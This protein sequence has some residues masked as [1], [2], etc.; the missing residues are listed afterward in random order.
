MRSFLKR[1]QFAWWSDRKTWFVTRK[2]FWGHIVE[3]VVYT[4]KDV[5]THIHDIG[6]IE[7]EL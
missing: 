2:V 1:N 7:I 6:M 4:K 5:K 3:M